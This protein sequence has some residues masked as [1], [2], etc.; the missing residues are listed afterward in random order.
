M[1]DSDL[2]AGAQVFRAGDA[3]GRGGLYNMVIP[4]GFERGAVLL[5]LLGFT[6]FEQVGRFRDAWVEPGEDGALLI[7]LYTRNGAGNRADYA[8]VIAALRAHPGYV[9]DA[10]DGHDPTYASFWFRVPP[11]HTTMLAPIAEDQ[12]VDTAARWKV[13]LGPL[14]E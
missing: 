9:R 14:G 11:E 5:P 6:A 3:Q 1:T 13:L 12:P 8:A 7:H 2:P 10:D 4:G